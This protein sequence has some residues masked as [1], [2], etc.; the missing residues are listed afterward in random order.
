MPEITLTKIRAAAQRLADAHRG[1]VAHATALEHALAQAATPIYAAHRAGIDAAAAEE[2]EA[3]A[4]LQR[5]IDAAPQLFYRPRSITVDGVKCGYRKDQD[6]IEYDDEAAVIA[7]I[8]ALPEL[9]EMAPVL[10]RTEEH[11]NRE[12]IDMIDP[13]Q[14]RRAGIRSVTGADQSFIAFSDTDVEKL[15]KAIM[16]DASK[17]QG[18]DEPKKKA[19]RKAVA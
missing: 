10:I 18:E 8:R 15:V 16:A 19:K 12:A 5:L 7:R 17:R 6:G 14:R 9:A 2:A 13:L 4:E 11:L 1:S 3:N